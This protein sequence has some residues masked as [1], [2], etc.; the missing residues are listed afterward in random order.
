MI[1][2]F[3][4]DAHVH[5]SLGE[6]QDPPPVCLRAAEATGLTTLAFTDHY[7]Q[8]ESRLSQRLEAYAQAAA[9]S[10]VRVIPG[11][12]CEI[13]DPQ[14]R[15]TLEESAGQRFSLVLAQIS[16]LT[17]GVAHAIPVRLD[18]LLDNLL[19]ALV[20]ACRRPQVNVLAVPFNLGRF[21]AALTPE[22][23]PSSLLEELAGV[24]REEEV[25]FEISN[26]MWTW[27]PDLPLDE[28]SEQ[29]ARLLMSFMRE[30]VKFVVGSGA[31]SAA[32]VGNLRY[33]AR[34]TELAGVERSQLVDISRLPA[35]PYS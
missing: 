12:V 26:M 11:A 18:S 20:G 9:T 35:L 16:A 13:L 7:A 30:G 10:S 15:L 4:Y 27:Y 31:R 29:Y 32:A 33:V 21:P 24:M 5:T 34:L 23:I 25:A 6:G 2:R 14:G 3:S 28:F 1:T 8:E 22:Q 17:E 19:S